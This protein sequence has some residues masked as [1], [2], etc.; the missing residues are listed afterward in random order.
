MISSQL[1]IPPAAFDQLNKITALFYCILTPLTMGLGI[2]GHSMIN[3]SKILSRIGML[4]ALI[5]FLFV[6][7]RL[8]LAMTIQR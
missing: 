8:I 1:N 2:V 6:F 7:T 4:L 3:D 5:P